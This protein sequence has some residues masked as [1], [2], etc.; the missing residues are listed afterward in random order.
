M[1]RSMGIGIAEWKSFADDVPVAKKLI[2]KGFERYSW[3]SFCPNV[4]YLNCS[5]ALLCTDDSVLNELLK[6]A[7]TKDN[8]LAAPT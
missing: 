1:S 5:R 7:D 8:M 3:Q 2:C 4:G 6:E